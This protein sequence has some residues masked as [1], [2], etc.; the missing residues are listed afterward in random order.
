MHVRVGLLHGGRTNDPWSDTTTDLNRGDAFEV[1]AGIASMA[2]GLSP[3]R[4][5]VGR[6]RTAGVTNRTLSTTARRR[7]PRR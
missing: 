1:F 2:A 6:R 7:A 4:G 5:A 3:A